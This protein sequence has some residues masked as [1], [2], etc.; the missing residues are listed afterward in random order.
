MLIHLLM[1]WLNLKLQPN[2]L[3]GNIQLEDIEMILNSAWLGRTGLVL[4]RTRLLLRQSNVSIE[5][6]G[7]QAKIRKKT[8]NSHDV[9]AR[10]ANSLEIDV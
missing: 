3:V 6:L 4:Q 7:A 5:R 10:E 2:F 9:L 8:L 1:Q